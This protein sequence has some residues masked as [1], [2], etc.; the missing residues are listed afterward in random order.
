MCEK[1]L[2]LGCDI[3]KGDILGRQALFYAVKNLDFDMT[4]VE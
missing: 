3:N 2:E 1:I 4:K